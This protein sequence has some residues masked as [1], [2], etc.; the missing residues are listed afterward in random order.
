MQ[1]TLK[2]V[3]FRQSVQVAYKASK[4]LKQRRFTENLKLA[5]LQSFSAPENEAENG[6]ASSP[7]L[8]PNPPVE[9]N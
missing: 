4:R 3:S 2:R 1:N 6:Q 8:L 5:G 7:P 9:V